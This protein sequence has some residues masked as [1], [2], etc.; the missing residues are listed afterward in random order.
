MRERIAIVGAGVSGLV[1]AYLLHETHDVVVYE[2]SDWIGGHTHTVD[3][4]DAAGV[5]PVDTGFIVFNEPNYPEFAAL[6]A[7]LGVASRPTSMSFSVRCD[8]SGIEYNGTSLDRLF[9]QRR[10][11]VRPDFLRM[12]RDIL[13]FHREAREA[14]AWP[15][16]TVT[17]ADFA[18]ERG[19]SPAFL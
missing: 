18:A 2:A 15:D 10:N 7:E 12:V 1:C 6:L 8:R 5:H 14:L 9:A 16:R 4:R 13:R 3:V 17:V 11:L 19:Y